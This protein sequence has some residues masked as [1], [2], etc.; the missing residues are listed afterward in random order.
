M[1]FDPKLK[2]AMTEIMS[3]LEKYDING[4][5]ILHSPG[6]GEHNMKVDA[7]YSCAKI[8][9]SPLGKAIHIQA[10]KEDIQRIEDTVN[11]I[12]IM[13]ELIGLHQNVCASTM[14]ALSKKLE[15]NSSDG[16][17]STDQELYN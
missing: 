14:Q 11:S 9:A 6:F 7:S 12:V 1:N 13:S 16:N 2:K 8:I 5:I 3:V 17:H 4:S 15:I 10:K